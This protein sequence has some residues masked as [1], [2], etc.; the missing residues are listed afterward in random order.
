WRIEEREVLDVTEAERLHSED[1]AGEAGALDLRIGEGGARGEALLVIEADADSVA[2]AP[3]APLSLIGARLRNP[4]D[5][6]ARRARPRIVAREAREPGVDDVDDP[7]DGERRLGDVRRQD[8]PALRD[9][10]EHLRL[11]RGG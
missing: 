2:H 3:A 11:L 10:R 7:G 5:L 6:E 4:L 8:H 9:A 1:D